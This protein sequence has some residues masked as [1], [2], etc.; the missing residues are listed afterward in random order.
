MHFIDLCGVFNFKEGSL[1]LTTGLGTRASEL[2]R[3]P[4]IWVP[5]NSLPGLF[6]LTT[7][8]SLPS[9]YALGSSLPASSL[10]SS[11]CPSLSHLVLVQYL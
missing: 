4:S 6:F 10:A 8:T 1:L 11:T 7:A 9:Q 5:T 2:L 3:T